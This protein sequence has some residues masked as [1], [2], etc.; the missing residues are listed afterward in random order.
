MLKIDRAFVTDLGSGGREGSDV[1]VRAMVDLAHSFGL[2]VVAEGVEDVATADLLRSMD[3]DQAQGFLYSPARP[4]TDLP[5]PGSAYFAVGMPAA[6]GSTGA[7]DEPTGD[8]PV[9]AGVGATPV[10]T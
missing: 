1:V 4:P 9:P 2:R 8:E 7:D 3:V 10:G 5:E 6:G